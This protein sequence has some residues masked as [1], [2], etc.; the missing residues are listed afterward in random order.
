MNVT[1]IGIKEGRTPCCG[2][3]CCQRD[4]AEHEGYDGAPTETRITENN[5]TNA[6]RVKKGL[7]EDILS[8][9]NLNKAY[10][11]VK[12]NKGAHG[13]DGMEVEHLLQYLKDNGDELTKS[14]LD[15]NYRPNPVRRVE[16]PKDNG[17]M[18]KLGIPTAVDRIVQQAIAQRLSPMFEPQFCETSYGFRPNRNA[19]DA[20][21]KCKE[22]ANQGYTYVVDMD[23]EKFFGAPG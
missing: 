18:R 10:K 20:L 11:R 23:L 21:K 17:K 13:V 4:S 7:L 1:G 16:I 14:I 2:K 8:A 5:T 19:H 15:G 22:Y 3:G 9:D 6:D 12:S